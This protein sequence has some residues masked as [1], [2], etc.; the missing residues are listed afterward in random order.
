[1]RSC[2]P[3]HL[4]PPSLCRG[5]S[6]YPEVLEA[7]RDASKAAAKVASGRQLGFDRLPRAVGSGEG[8]GSI[9]QPPMPSVT[10]ICGF[11]PYGVPT[12]TMPRWIKGQSA[13]EDCRLLAAVGGG[14]ARE[15]PVALSSSRL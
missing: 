1:M 3:V 7:V 5:G 6:A 9:G 4:P 10:R 11:C 15:I 8:A 14:G 2:L 13:V 12:N